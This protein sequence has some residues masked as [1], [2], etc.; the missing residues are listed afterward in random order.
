MELTGR[1]KSQ[2]FVVLCPNLEF[3]KTAAELNIDT[4]LIKDCNPEFQNFVNLDI[5]ISKIL[6]LKFGDLFKQWC[7]VTRN[8]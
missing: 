8:L 6:L 4:S 1:V 2:T 7:G 5:Y 3:L